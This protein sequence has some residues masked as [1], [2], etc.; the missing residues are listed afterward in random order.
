MVEKECL[1]VIVIIMRGIIMRSIL[2]LPEV[3]RNEFQYFEN[4]THCNEFHQNGTGCIIANKNR[5]VQ[6]TNTKGIFLS[7]SYEVQA[8][9]QAV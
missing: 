7:S 3:E 2:K 8:P 9:S 6:N 5:M 4:V 1:S